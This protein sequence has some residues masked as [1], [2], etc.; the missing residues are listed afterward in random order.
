VNRKNVPSLVKTKK[1]KKRETVGQHSTDVAVLDWQDR[2]RA[3]LI[4]TYHN[5]EMSTISK[6]GKEI[7]KPKVAFDYNT[8]MGGVDLKDQML[9]PYL[10]E[11]KKGNK[12]YIKFFKRLINVAIH[13]T[14]VL[15]RTTTGN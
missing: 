14:M 11:T 7:I 13:N 2:K 10:L 5:G 9:Q 1:L 15:F 6:D 12:W 3:T 8:N 4:S